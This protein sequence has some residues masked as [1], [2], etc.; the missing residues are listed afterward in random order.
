MKIGRL[1]IISIAVGVMSFCIL[2]FLSIGA[3]SLPIQLLQYIHNMSAYALVMMSS[4]IAV[5]VFLL[6]ILSSKKEENSNDIEIALPKRSKSLRWLNILTIIVIIG[7]MVYVG[8]GQKEE[9]EQHSFGFEEMSEARR[10]IGDDNEVVENEGIPPVQIV[11]D[12]DK[13]TVDVFIKNDVLP[14]PKLLI[15]DTALIYLCSH[16][17]FLELCDSF[18]MEGVVAFT[19]SINNYIYIDV[20]TY[21]LRRVVTHEMAHNYDYKNGAISKR[22]DFID[23]YNEVIHTDEF[24]SLLPILNVEY[25]ASDPTEFYA[26]VSDAYFNKTKS[27]EV[28]YPSLFVYFDDIYKE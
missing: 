9:S 13:E 19:T 23:Y 22:A 2:L 21:D 1:I 8:L 6:G 20:S 4:A 7:A 15:E 26:E 5:C 28:A 11:G 14:Q 12:I 3:T 18:H 16:E 25:A 27:L 17:R 24:K 10:I